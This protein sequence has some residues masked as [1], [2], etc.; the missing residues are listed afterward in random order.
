MNE[1]LDLTQLRAV[2]EAATP[3]PWT[4]EYDN[5]D[6]WEAGIN[7]GDY[8]YA[9]QGPRNC[10]Y[11]NWADKRLVKD[12]LNRVSEISQMVDEDA[13]FIAA[14]DPPT[15]LALLVRVERAE[16]QVARVRAVCESDAYEVSNEFGDY[17][18][19]AVEN[20]LD[21]LDGESNE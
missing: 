19:V 15:I 3:G 21:A 9:L 1:N 10:S 8:P 7:D 14:F 5:A 13:K 12:E 6:D 18:A 16:Q 17:D 11:D 20:I 2:A 4:L